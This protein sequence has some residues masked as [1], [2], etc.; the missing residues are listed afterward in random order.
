V[1]IDKVTFFFLKCKIRLNINYPN[2]CSTT[3]DQSVADDLFDQHFV[4]G[5]PSNGSQSSTPLTGIAP[6]NIKFRFLIVEE[7]F[8]LIFIILEN[9]HVGVIAQ[10]RDGARGRV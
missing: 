6:I 8:H 2:V 7:D 9:F 1:F 5:Q 4:V 10:Q 3:M